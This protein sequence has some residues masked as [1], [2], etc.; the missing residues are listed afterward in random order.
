MHRL[1]KSLILVMAAAA[2]LSS[3][4]VTAEE[5]PVERNDVTAGDIRRE[6]GDVA[7]ASGSYIRQKKD[8]YQERTEAFISRFETKVKRLYER[9]EGAGESTK[10]RI[11]GAADRIRKKSD[12]AQD[13]L[14]KLK[15][16]SGEKW[17]SLKKEIDSIMADIERTYKKAVSGFGND[18]NKYENKEAK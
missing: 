13:R 15:E 5:R 7:D 3:A 11:S 8:E 1:M 9:M 12:A 6:A 14:I 2:C 17:H 10:E 18:D 16:A 4:P